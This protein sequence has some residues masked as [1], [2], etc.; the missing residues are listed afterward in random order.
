M[1]STDSKVP[2]IYP[3]FKESKFKLFLLFKLKNQNIKAPL[4]LV[5]K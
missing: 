5:T 2:E 1:F 3:V 4:N